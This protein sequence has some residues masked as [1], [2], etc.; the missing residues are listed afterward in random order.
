MRGRA[1]TE[2]GVRYPDGSVA[3]CGY[4]D[5]ISEHFARE[6]MVPD[7]RMVQVGLAPEA[8]VTRQ[9]TIHDD[10]LTEWVDVPRSTNPDDEQ[11]SG[12]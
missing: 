12:R 4:L 8:V 6:A 10:D 5:G 9:R 2:W 1:V 7:E 11:E 3:S